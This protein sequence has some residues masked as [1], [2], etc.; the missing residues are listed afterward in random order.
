MWPIAPLR[1]AP[2]RG[3][4]L[5]EMADAGQGEF[6]PQAQQAPD[7]EVDQRFA[8]AILWPQAVIAAR[9]R[10]FLRHSRHEILD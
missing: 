5:S 4:P 3:P 10:P 6:D 2:A 7:F 1:I 9:C 8:S